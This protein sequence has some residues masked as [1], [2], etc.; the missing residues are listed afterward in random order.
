MTSNLERLA[1]I[2]SL[3]REAPIRREFE[4]LLRIGNA[5]LHDAMNET[6]SKESRFDLAYN[7]AHAFALAALR[8]HGY[9]PPQNARFVVFQALPHT[10]G[11]PAAKWRLLAKCHEMR[12]RMEYE[13][14]VDI[15]ETLLDDLV[16]AARELRDAAGNVPVPGTE[17][18]V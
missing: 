4:G 11:T 13:G 14:E 10:L 17:P 7:A 15:D 5:R 3:H 12:N 2:G 16:E 18:S 8:S 1:Q 6:N 9:R